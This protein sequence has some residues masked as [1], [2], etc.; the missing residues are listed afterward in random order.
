MAKKKKKKT[1]SKKKKSINKKKTSTKSKKKKSSVN[2]KKKNTNTVKNKKTIEEKPTKK[3]TKVKKETIVPKEEPKVIDNKK[4]NKYL[5]IIPVIII[6][7]ALIIYKSYKYLYTAPTPSINSV[8]I[9]EDNRLNVSINIDKNKIK[10]KVYCYISTIDQMPDINDSNWVLADNYN[11]SFEIDKQEYYVYVKNEDTTIIKVEGTDELG[12]VT[13][14]S[15]ENKNK[16]YLPI[17]G[18]YNISATFD[19][20]GNINEDLKYYSDN[21]SVATVSSN[22]TITGIK[23]GSSKIHVSIGD[24]DDYIEV[25]VTNLITT[26]PSKGYDYKK[27]YLGCNKYSKSDNDLIDEILKSRI[28]NVGYKTRAGVVEAARFLTL[29]FPYRIN[30]FYENGRQTTNNVDG[31]GRYYHVGF[32]LHS[33][34][35]KNI[36]GSRKGPK[37]WGC[38][39]Y[40]AP[41]HRK[42]SNGLVCS[43]FVSWALLNGGFNVKDVGA[44]WSNRRD[45]TDYGEVKKITTSLS[46]SNK[47]KVGDL[48]HSERAGGHIGIIVGIDKNN[49][50]VAQ[51]LWYGEKGVV[52]TKI[53]KSKLKNHFPH[54]VLM[55]KYYKN[56]GKLTNMW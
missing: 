29:D 54:V 9:G 24:K 34:R 25:L 44:G 15:I 17:K 33:S 39:L 50:Y 1:I 4:N 47:I 12:K 35:Y 21:E 16:V 13:S 10:N 55:D 53:K 30:Y 5:I 45:L 36:T 23:K 6:V 43:G 48:L 46:T 26:R 19:Y 27:A 56:D 40:S 14:L 37:T 41:A 22:G 11:C 2:S 31:E 3:T 51:A 28:E 52:I 42:M 18:K 32:Y 20:I 49:Y 38:S 7:L 8:F